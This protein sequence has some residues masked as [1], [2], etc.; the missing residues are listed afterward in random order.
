MIWEPKTRSPGLGMRRDCTEEVT[1]KL[2]VPEWLETPRGRRKWEESLQYCAG[3]F[4][5]LKASQSS[6]F[7][8]EGRGSR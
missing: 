7:F 4:A 6:L 2:L 5:E 8:T 1:L 3:V